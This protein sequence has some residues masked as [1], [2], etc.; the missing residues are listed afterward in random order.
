MLFLSS[1]TAS[2]CCRL[3]RSRTICYSSRLSSAVIKSGLMPSPLCYCDDLLT[4]NIDLLDLLYLFFCVVCLILSHRSLP[5]FL[6]P[7]PLRCLMYVWCVCLLSTSTF[8]PSAH[9]TLGLP[10]GT[11]IATDSHRPRHGISLR[12]SSDSSG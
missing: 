8:S 7:R 2:N 6:L 10:A 1:L 5:F 9:S 11:H 4:F 12:V 3:V